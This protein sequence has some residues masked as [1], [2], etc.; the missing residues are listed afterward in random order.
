MFYVFGVSITAARQLALRTTNR[1]VSDGKGKRRLSDAEFEQKVQE[2][3]L[4]KYDEMKPVKLSHSL[5]TPSL[6]KDYIKLALTQGKHRNFSIRYRE[7]TGKINPKT[8]KP[9]I[10]WVSQLTNVME[11]A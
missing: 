3:T 10:K 5:S 1:L 11:V 2:N 7:P 9:A 4:I 6:C 8:R